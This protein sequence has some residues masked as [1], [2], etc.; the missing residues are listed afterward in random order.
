MVSKWQHISLYYMRGKGA[1][2]GK[3]WI[4]DR[5]GVVHALS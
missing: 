1:A 4:E 5:I 3:A 2:A